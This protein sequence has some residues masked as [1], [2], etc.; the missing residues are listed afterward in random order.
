[1]KPTWAVRLIARTS[2]APWS[3]CVPSRANIPPGAVFCCALRPA[4]CSRFRQP[5]P[6]KWPCV[7]ASCSCEKN[8]IASRS[9]SVMVAK[10][11]LRP[12]S[13]SSNV[14][15]ARKA[16]YSRPRVA[17]FY[18]GRA[19]F[20]PASRFARWS[21]LRGRRR[22]FRRPSERCVRHAGGPAAFP[23]APPL[24]G[25]Q[26]FG[27]SRGLA[28]VPGASFLSPWRGVGVGPSPGPETV[29]FSPSRFVVRVLGSPLVGCSRVCAS[30]PPP[31]IEAP[32]P[33]RSM[34][35]PP[36]PQSGL[37]LGQKAG[38]EP[39]RSPRARF[40]CS[41]RCGTPQ[42]PTEI[43]SCGRRPRCRPR[44]ARSCLSPAPRESPPQFPTEPASARFG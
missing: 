33:K 31:R 41:S 9:S 15:L 43:L 19:L 27:R 32:E 44:S 12:R 36:S 10:V 18:G 40:L 7:C 42:S 2:R 14:F 11:F 24:P 37:V 13:T 39:V 4:A 16:A 29:L 28:L 3:R 20:R 38:I 25:P 21:P 6:T 8:R 35:R 1:V 23:I 22:R 26:L 30:G 17:S 5:P 34:H